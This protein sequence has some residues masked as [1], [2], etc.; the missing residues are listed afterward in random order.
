MH[1]MDLTRSHIAERTLDA[2]CKFRHGLYSDFA[3]VLFYAL[4]QFRS[5]NQDDLRAGTNGTNK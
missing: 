3:I 4:N 5:F 2:I 1:R